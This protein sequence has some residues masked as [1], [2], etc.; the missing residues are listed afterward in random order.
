MQIQRRRIISLSM[1]KNEQ[2]IIEPFIRHNARYVDFMVILDNASVDETRRIVLDCARELKT[3][4]V[5]DSN[6]LAYNQAERMTRLLHYCQSA[7]FADFVLL[8][9]A[10]EFISAPD[11]RALEQSLNTIPQGG[12]GLI[13]W[14]TFILTPSEIGRLAEDPPQSLHHRRTIELPL[15]RKAVLRL[16]GAYRPDLQIEQGNHGIR[17]DSGRPVPT[18][19]LEDLYLMH[20]PV[21]S[22]DQ[23]VCK[24]VVGWMAYLARNPAARS[25]GD[26]FQWRDAFDRVTTV[27]ASALNDSDL[28]EI[29]LRYAQRR[30]EIDW[31]KDVVED[32][33]PSDLGRRYS[34]GRFADPIALV[35][36]S[37]ERS[38]TPPAPLAEF[39]RPCL[40]NLD[41][42]V[43]GSAFDAAWHWDN[44]L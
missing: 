5:A 11:R 7:F 15:F 17:T 13:P 3:I 22:R 36:R 42:A 6:E 27:E 35:A 8:L 32:K 1:V 26:G 20:F 12:A 43:A 19:L 9:D 41:P 33:P 23:L 21:R 31:Q 38:L 39:T 16:D 10:D 34:T 24:S 30:S 4:I 14:R 37:W 2:D 25:K 40:E 18:V 29:S 44:F 28:C